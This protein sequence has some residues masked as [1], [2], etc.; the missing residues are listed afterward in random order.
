MKY[1]VLWNEITLACEAARGDPVNP[2]AREVLA[3]PSTKHPALDAPVTSNSDGTQVIANAKAKMIDSVLLVLQE[4]EDV[5]TSLSRL[6]VVHGRSGKRSETSDY[7]VAALT[8]NS[9]DSYSNNQHF[10][11]REMSQSTL[12]PRMD[13]IGM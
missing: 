10:Q 3:D 8:L 5:F 4:F 11:R 12:R 9:G 6:F 13:Y 7:D 2:Y 1:A